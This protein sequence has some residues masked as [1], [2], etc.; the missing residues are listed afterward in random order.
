VTVQKTILL[1]VYIMLYL[2]QKEQLYQMVVILLESIS[3][4]V[5]FVS[6]WNID[7]W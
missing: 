7:S 5:N 4:L 1:I 3:V 6:K 2:G